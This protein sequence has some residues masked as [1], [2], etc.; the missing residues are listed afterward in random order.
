MRVWGC[1]C[2]ERIRHGPLKSEPGYPNARKLIYLGEST[3]GK[4]YR[5]LDPESREVVH[6]FDVSFNEDMSKRRSDLRS[7]DTRRKQSR[8]ER[9]ASDTLIYNDLDDIQGILD[10]RNLF[11][12]SEPEFVAADSKPVGN[13]PFIRSTGKP[14]GISP[15]VAAH[16][17]GSTEMDFLVVSASATVAG[18]VLS[19]CSDASF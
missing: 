16:E 3:D 6:A 14:F 13:R 15:K 12:G 9:E 2:Y 5:C 10:Y 7:F 1:D 11:D 18:A 4:S 17:E 19:F 8:D